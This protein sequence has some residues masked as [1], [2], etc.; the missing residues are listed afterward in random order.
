MDSYR[1]NEKS[2]DQSSRCQDD[3]NSVK[4]VNNKNYRMM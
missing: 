2:G 3:K 1:E 4:S